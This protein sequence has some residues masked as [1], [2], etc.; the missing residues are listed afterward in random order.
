MEKESRIDERCEPG[1]GIPSPPPQTPRPPVFSV[2]P[3]RWKNNNSPCGINV[4]W[5]PESDRRQVREMEPGVPSA[6][7]RRKENRRE[8]FWAPS[9]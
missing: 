2:Q 7:E 3:L 4:K 1:G 5:L 9:K 8:A 6:S